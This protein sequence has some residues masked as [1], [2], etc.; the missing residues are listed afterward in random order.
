MS[1]Y[2]YIGVSWAG[3]LVLWEHN[4]RACKCRMCKDHLKIGDGFK[5]KKARVSLM[6][7]G[8][9]CSRCVG[10]F[11]K[12][13]E[14]WGWNDLIGCLYPFNEILLHPRNGADLACAWLDGGIQGL[15]ER[16]K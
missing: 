9:V 1:G 4:K 12:T 11:I 16:L 10:E 8:Y 2:I 14:N 13:V 7:S 3:K 6:Q 15:E 5:F